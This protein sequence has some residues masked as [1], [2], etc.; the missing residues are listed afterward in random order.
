MVP[1]PMTP[2][3]GFDLALVHASLLENLIDVLRDVQAW[4]GF[5]NEVVDH[6]REVPPVFPAP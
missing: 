3:Q 4:D 5:L 6:R 2:Y 1:M